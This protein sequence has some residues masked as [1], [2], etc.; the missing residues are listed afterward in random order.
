MS[1]LHLKCTK[2]IYTS[3]KAC[4]L[5]CTKCKMDIHFKIL[6]NVMNIRFTSII[7]NFKWGLDDG[8]GNPN[9]QIEEMGMHN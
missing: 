9:A 4:F 3:Q 8:K 7:L 2:L 6:L 1:G 5:Q